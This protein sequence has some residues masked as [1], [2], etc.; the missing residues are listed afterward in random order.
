M[1]LHG[2]QV[3]ISINGQ[4]VAASKTCDIHLDVELIEVAPQTDG[5]CRE[6]IPGRLSWKVTTGQLVQQFSSQLLLQVGAVVSLRITVN[7]EQ[8][9]TGDGE[10]IVSRCAVQASVGSLANGQFEFTGSGYLN[11]RL[12]DLF[13][14]TVLSEY[15]RSVDGKKLRIRWH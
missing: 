1:I 9:M 5:A 13:L 3:I 15:V 10:A 12:N 11:N 4:A 2:E 6:F 7:G 14:G 8:T